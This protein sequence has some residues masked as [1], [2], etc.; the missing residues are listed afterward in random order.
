M[1]SGF[2]PASAA[3]ARVR[4]CSAAAPPSSARRGGSA[5]VA[6]GEDDPS[7]WSQFSGMARAASGE[8]IP[9]TGMPSRGRSLHP[10]RRST[11]PAFATAAVSQDHDQPGVRTAGNEMAVQQRFQIASDRGTAGP[12]LDLEG[13]LPRGCAVGAAADD[14]K[15]RQIT[16]RLRD[17]ALGLAGRDRLRQPVSDL[18]PR[19]GRPRRSRRRARLRPGWLRCRR[20]CGTTIC[21]VAG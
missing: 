16:H 9:A 3:I 1:R 19:R 12:L 18:V 14:L 4:R 6:G 20:P 8:R 10:L 15:Q 17:L 7:G 11:P 13:K 21:R 5:S 2:T